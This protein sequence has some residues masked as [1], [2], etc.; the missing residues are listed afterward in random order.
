MTRTAE[1]FKAGVFVNL[2]EMQLQLLTN[3]PA[4]DRAVVEGAAELVLGRFAVESFGTDEAR[5]ALKESIVNAV[6]RRFTVARGSA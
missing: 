1:A 3:D 6:V 2:V 4:V 5:A